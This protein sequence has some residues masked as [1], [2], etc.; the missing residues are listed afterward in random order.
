MEWGEGALTGRCANTGGQAA[1]EAHEK[2]ESTN[3]ASTRH[4][5]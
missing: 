3:R 2:D 1:V 4:W 5:S